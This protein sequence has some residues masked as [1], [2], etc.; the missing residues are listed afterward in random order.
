MEMMD[1]LNILKIKIMVQFFFFNLFKYFH[2]FI[3]QKIT[4]KE[5]IEPS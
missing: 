2:N 3:I 1:T 5:N 4:E